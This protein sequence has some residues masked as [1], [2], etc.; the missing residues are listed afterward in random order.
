MMNAQM[1]QGQM[2]QGQGGGGGGGMCMG[3][4]GGG[5]GSNNGNL[6]ANQMGFSRGPGAQT[7]GGIYAQVLPSG[8]SSQGSAGSGTR[9]GQTLQQSVLATYDTN[10]SGKLEGAELAATQAAA[11]QRRHRSRN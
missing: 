2:Q 11:T 8:S 7:P 1:Q 9:R 6:S 4:M 3:Q 10:A 5:M